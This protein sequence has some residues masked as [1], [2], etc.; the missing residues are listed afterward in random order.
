MINPSIFLKGAKIFRLDNITS[1]SGLLSIEFE[2]QGEKYIPKKRTY[3]E[4]Q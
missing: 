3:L 4:N 1:R 2:F